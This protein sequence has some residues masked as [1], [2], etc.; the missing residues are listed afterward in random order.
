[1]TIV[2]SYQLHTYGT[3]MV[4]SIVVFRRLVPFQLLPLFLTFSSPFS[5]TLCNLKSSYI[6]TQA[7]MRFQCPTC[8]YR[9]I[10]WL[11]VLSR[12]RRLY[13]YTFLYM[14]MWIYIWSSSFYGSLVFFRNYFY[15]TVRIILLKLNNCYYYHLIGRRNVFQ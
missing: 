7:K 1:M 9:I 5:Y 11:P 14:Q 8:S 10:S 12:F 3:K 15:S 4:S 13:S 2:T 6:C